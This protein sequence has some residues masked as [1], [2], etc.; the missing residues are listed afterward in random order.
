MTSGQLRRPGNEAMT[1]T[2]CECPSPGRQARWAKNRGGLS[3]CWQTPEQPYISPPYRLLHWSVGGAKMPEGA[4][5]A[6]QEFEV[7]EADDALHDFGGAHG[8]KG[9]DF[10][11]FWVIQRLTELEPTKPD[12]S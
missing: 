10:A 6:L 1:S 11:S 8:S 3:S 4:S 2:D 9:H 7:I 5:T 12:D